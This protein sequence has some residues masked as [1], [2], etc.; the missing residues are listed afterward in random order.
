MFDYNW[1]YF[2]WYKLG[3]KPDKSEHSKKPEKERGEIE[4]RVE[5][6]IKPKAGS[7]MDLSFK[8]KDKSLSLKNLKDKSNN[9]KQSLGDKF[10]I[11]LKSRKP[12]FTGENQVI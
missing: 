9:L 12:K 11:S 6:V 10:K 2:R 3:G 8:T 5:F 1:F 7:L 4:V